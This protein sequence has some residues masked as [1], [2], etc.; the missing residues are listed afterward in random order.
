MLGRFS[1]GANRHRREIVEMWPD[2]VVQVLARLRVFLLDELRVVDQEPQRR[3]TGGYPAQLTILR[4]RQSRGELWPRKAQ[5][6]D[7]A[8]GLGIQRFGQRH[9]RSLAGVEHDVAPALAK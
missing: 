9:E 8:A 3:R 6:E 7:V 1:C 4:R 2:N 5:H